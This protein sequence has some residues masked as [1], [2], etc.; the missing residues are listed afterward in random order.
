MVN[1]AEGLFEVQ[2]KSLRIAIDEKTQPEFHPTFLEFRRVVQAGT[3]KEREIKFA[4]HFIRAKV[5]KRNGK[6][7]VMELGRIAEAF[8]KKVIMAKRWIPIMQQDFAQY[9]RLKDVYVELQGLL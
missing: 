8:Y 3:S 6:H 2:G 9:P 4:A 7:Q 1:I 5:I